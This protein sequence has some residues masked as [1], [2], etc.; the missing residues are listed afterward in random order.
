MSEFSEFSETKTLA[1]TTQEERTWGMIVHLSSLSGFLFGAGWIIA[2]LIIWLVK[3]E[4]MP[5]VN[6]EGKKALN[7]QITMAIAAII[8]GIL[9]IVLVG[10]VGLLAIAIL[11]IIFPIM[12]GLKAN[13]GESYTYPLSIPFLK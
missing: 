8:S 6:Q 4:E 7:F 12:A 9:I 5:F 1:P 10:F 3:R 2:P 13:E 11:Q